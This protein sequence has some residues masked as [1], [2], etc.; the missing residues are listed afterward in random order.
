MADDELIMFTL[1]SLMAEVRWTRPG[2]TEERRFSTVTRKIKIFS[3]V[4]T[5]IQPW[6]GQAEHGNQESQVTGMPYKSVFEVNWFIYHAVNDPSMFGSIEN[7]LIIKGVRDVLAPKVNDP[8]W[9]KQ[10][11]L[12]GLVHHC[13]IGGRV[14][15]D[16]GDIDNQAMI[17]IPIK[18]LVP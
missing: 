13:H 6:C 3:D 10:N 15:K 8:G 2:E 16:P 14:F 4:P 11:T 7:N 5:D 18:V 12:G 9:P 17:I 1:A